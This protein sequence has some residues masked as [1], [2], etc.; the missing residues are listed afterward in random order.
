MTQTSRAARRARVL[1]LHQVVEQAFRV[2]DGRQVQLR[3]VV[4]SGE[5]GDFDLAVKQVAVTHVV[6]EVFA[7]T[8]P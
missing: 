3:V 7:Q 4:A 6:T 5:R 8:V 2:R 1:F